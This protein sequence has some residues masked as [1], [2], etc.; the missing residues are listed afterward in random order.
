MCCVYILLSRRLFD[1][2]IL[3]PR[4]G[5]RLRVKQRVPACFRAA[6]GS[7][8]PGKHCSLVFLA[9]PPLLEN[10]AKIDS[11]LY[12][13]ATKD[14]SALHTENCCLLGPIF[15]HVQRATED[16]WF[17]D[18]VATYSATGE[19]TGPVT[20]EPSTYKQNFLEATPYS[21]QEKI[22][23]NTFKAK[24]GLCVIVFS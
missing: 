2:A 6:S 5:A 8:H 4:T 13:K 10:Q 23:V 7:F 11:S 3:R 9:A 16:P 1:D 22:P 15:L 19:S 20:G 12:S 21:N 17:P 24:V 18:A 14:T